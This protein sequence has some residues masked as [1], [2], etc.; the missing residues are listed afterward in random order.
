MIP[1]AEFHFDPEFGHD[2]ANL[3]DLGVILLP[4]GS[5]AGITPVALPPADYLTELAARGGLRHQLFVNV[6]YGVSASLEGPPRFS[7]DGKRK[8][9]KSPFMALQPNWLG[10]LMNPHATGEGGDC[11]GDSGSPKF[12]D[13]HPDMIVATVTW[14]DRP[15]RATTWDY[16]L[17]TPSARAFL[18][19]YVTLP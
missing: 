1:A 10:L 2:Q 5:T 3:H 9:S 4:E 15:C 19:N 14:G 17:D 18:T 7:F 6:G 12:L 13:G 11:F 16:R 8:A